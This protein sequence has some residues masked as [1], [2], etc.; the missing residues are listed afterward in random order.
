MF[1]IYTRA[2]EEANYTASIFLQ[3]L[4]DEGGVRTAKKLINAPNPSVGYTA[5]WE[6]DC[7]HLTVE[8]VVVGDARWHS[9]FDPSE[10]E[11]AGRR[12]KQ[13]GYQRRS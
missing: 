2:K 1:D 7:L 12:L 13:Y 5:L 8:A 9:L 6:R 3:M 4:G 10:I 11:R